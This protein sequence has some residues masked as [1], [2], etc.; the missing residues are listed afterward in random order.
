MGYGL[1]DVCHYYNGKYQS[2]LIAFMQ[3]VYTAEDLKRNAQKSV[4]LNLRRY[5]TVA[6]LKCSI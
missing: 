6:K 3:V 5:L 2:I 1:Q 4:V